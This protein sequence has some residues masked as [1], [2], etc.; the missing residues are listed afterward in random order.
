LVDE[1][2]AGEAHVRPGDVV[3]IRVTTV[4]PSSPTLAVPVQRV[5]RRRVNLA[6]AERVQLPSGKQR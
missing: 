1:A 5:G 6:T 3:R 2:T 4:E